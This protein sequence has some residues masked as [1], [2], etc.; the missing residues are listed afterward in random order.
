MAVREGGN[1]YLSFFLCLFF[2]IEGEKKFEKAKQLMDE[3]IH[4]LPNELVNPI[5]EGNY[6]FVPEVELG[7]RIGEPIPHKTWMLATVYL[8]SRLSLLHR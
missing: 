7:E 3:Y 5:I 8:R 4:N 6:D 1:S 2:S